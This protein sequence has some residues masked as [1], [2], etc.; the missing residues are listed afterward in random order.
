MLNLVVDR[1]KVDSTTVINI[2]ETISILKKWNQNLKTKLQVTYP[3]VGN[4]ISYTPDVMVIP[5]HT[6]CN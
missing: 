4:G 6:K 1:F 5:P 2:N 3:K